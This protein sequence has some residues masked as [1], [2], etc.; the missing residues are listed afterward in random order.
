M[1]VDVAG[2]GD[3]RRTNRDQVAVREGLYRALRRAFIRSGLRWERCHREDRGDGVLILV[4][5]EVPKELLAGRLPVELASELEAHNGGAGPEAR[6]RLRAAVHAGEVQHDDHGVAGTAINLAFRLLEAGPLKD[7]LRGSPGTLALIAS[8]WFYEE[9]IRHH[10]ASDPK[11]YR[12]VPVAVKETLTRGW[13]RLP[14]LPGLPSL[15]GLVLGRAPGEPEGPRQLPAAVRDFVGRDAELALLDDRLTPGDDVVIALVTGT[16]GVGKTAL[17]VHAA[18]RARHRF[19]GGQLYVDLRGYA[20]EPALAPEQ[21]LEG[22]LH[23]LGVPAGR[24]P[25]PPAARSALYRS[26]LDG[27]RVLIVLDNAASAAQVR[28]LLP[29]APGCAVLVTGRG[30]L[31]GLTAREGARPLELAPLEPAESR[32]LLRRIVGAERVDAEPGAAADLAR[33]CAHLP[34]ALR[35][36]AERAAARPGLR[37][38]GLVR[39]LDER[40]RLDVLGADDEHTAPRTVL[41]WSY[42]ALPPPAARM[43]R[44]LALHPGAEVSP[45][46]A[47][48]LAGAGPGEARRLL[49]RLVRAHLLEEAAPG[50]RYRLTGL[51]RC[52][53]AELA[54]TEEPR[55][56]RSAAVRRVLAWYLHTADDAR[57]LLCPHRVAPRLTVPDGPPP[58]RFRSAREAREWCESERDNLVAA[59]RHAPA[60]GHH[61]IGW[62]LPLALWT[63][64]LPRGP[65][66][67]WV[68]AHRGALD[69]ARHSGDDAG[70]AYAL[71]ALGFARQ[72]RG[73]FEE[74]ANHFLSAQLIFKYVRDRRGEAWA[75]HGLGYALRRL[76]RYDEAILLHRQALRISTEIGDAGG[77]AWSLGGLGF[78][79]AGR[80]RHAEALNHF[81]RALCIARGTDRRAEGWALYGLGHAYQ[82]LG[83]PE[84]ATGHY[85]RALEIFREIGDWR[86]R[87]ETLDGLGKAHLRAGRPEAAR[88]CWT[89]ALEAFQDLRSPQAS[90]VRDRL[91]ILDDDTVRELPESEA[92]VPSP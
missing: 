40:N 56:D 25:A 54:E 35:V 21:A 19:P 72:D 9:V 78:A 20:A 36:A 83:R 50:G 31:S 5:S 6:I 12:Q 82:T 51:L 61:D 11:A 84:Q 13:V 2:Y 33:H 60:T 8:E 67:D 57:R 23:A 38:A 77:R 49:D 3:H 69:S 26:L 37:L 74:A 45:G 14:G 55:R 80:R 65:W 4:P 79:Y 81:E 28:P 43:F 16:P 7:A 73:R 85:G 70:E 87:G 15:S 91:L 71:G 63:L 66:T 47:T 52:Y 29:G 41:S 30:D 86:G 22:V 46:A 39:E 89:R 48:A 34:L 90:R 32:A 17:A 42:H 18:H 53:A 62:R 92:A 10:P 76:H 24:I 88:A 59:V 68:A 75:L 64:C 1:C 58:R 27:R 44:L